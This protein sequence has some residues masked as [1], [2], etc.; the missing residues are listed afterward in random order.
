MLY[1]WQQ[2]ISAYRNRFIQINK[3]SRS[4]ETMVWMKCKYSERK[5]GRYVFLRVIREIE[6]ESV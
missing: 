2:F 4:Q 3:V 6:K 5:E 1:A